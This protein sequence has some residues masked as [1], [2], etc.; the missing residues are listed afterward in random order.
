M[1]KGKRVTQCLN[2]H[3]ADMEKREYKT[4]IRLNRQMFN[5]L[6][7][8]FFSK[9]DLQLETRQCQRYYG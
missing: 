2:L 7:T 3:Y 5:A 1:Q 9:V 6:Y 8:V 4:F